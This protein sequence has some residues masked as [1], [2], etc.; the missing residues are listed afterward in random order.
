[1]PVTLV[2][3]CS[4]EK[5]GLKTRKARYYAEQLTTSIGPPS[6]GRRLSGVRNLSVQLRKIASK[7]KK[8]KVLR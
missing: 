6:S 4:F 1:R 5:Q 3:P 7:N 8:G 2:G